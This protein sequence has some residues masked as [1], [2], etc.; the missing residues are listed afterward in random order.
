M[1]CD[2]WIDRSPRP[3][4]APRV[5]MPVLEPLVK[6]RRDT[7]RAADKCI[8][9]PLVGN[10]GRRGIIHGAPYKGGRCKRC[11][12]LKTGGAS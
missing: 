9:G 10:V 6:A 5:P 7:L 12:D 8:N 3:A 11:W 2:P 1:I 4:K